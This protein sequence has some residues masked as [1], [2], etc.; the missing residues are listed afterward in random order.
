MRW[1]DWLRIGG[2]S[3]AP[4]ATAAACG[5]HCA[6]QPGNQNFAVHGFSRFQLKFSPS[7]FFHHVGIGSLPQQKPK[8]AKGRPDLC[9]DWRSRHPAP[10]AASALDVSN[11]MSLMYCTL[12]YALSMFKEV[13]DS[14]AT[15]NYFQA[16]SSSQTRPVSWN[17]DRAIGRDGS[18]RNP[19]ASSAMPPV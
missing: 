14:L 18:S 2:R 8:D 7:T 3:V 16:V 11:P 13:V 5:Q 4:A 10:K 17:S 12:F 1:V 19:S 9:K 6:K 15:R